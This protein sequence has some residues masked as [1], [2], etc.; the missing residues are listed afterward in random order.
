MKSNVRANFNCQ[1]DEMSVTTIYDY[2]VT[3]SFRPGL[4][5]DFLWQRISNFSFMCVRAYVSVC[6]VFLVFCFF[7]RLIFFV[8]FLSR[9]P[10]Y[11][12]VI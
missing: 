6:V 5:F 11:T 2:N 4:I 7:F 9:N 1:V 12:L 3:D 8:L 10:I